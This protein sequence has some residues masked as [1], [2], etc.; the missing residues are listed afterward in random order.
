MGTKKKIIGGHEAAA[1]QLL[2]EAEAGSYEYAMMDVSTFLSKN[3]FPTMPSR[4][5]EKYGAVV[6]A[7]SQSKDDGVKW[8]MVV[9]YRIDHKPGTANEKEVNLD[10]LLFAFDTGS[11]QSKPTAVQRYHGNF[12]SRSFDIQS[13]ASIDQ[14]ITDFR[15]ALLPEA[16]SFSSAPPEIKSAMQYMVRVYKS[17]ILGST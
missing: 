3:P 12:V 13:T 7:F 11:N 8:G 10:P 15:A 2:K 14:A 4:S 6:V 17:K 16:G 9:G 5:L 1:E